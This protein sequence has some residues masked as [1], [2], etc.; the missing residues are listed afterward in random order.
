M[1]NLSIRIGD[2][3]TLRKK[4]TQEE[5][6]AY[7]KS[8]LDENPVHFDMDYASKTVFKK[9]IVHGLFAASLFGGLLGSKLPGKGTIHLGQ[10]LKFIKPIFI[11]EQ[12]TATIEII[13][14]RNDKPIVT[15]NCYILKENN[16]IAIEGKAIVMYKGEFFV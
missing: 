7:A 11:G 3:A 1:N 13:D 12:V 14:I 2:K 16:S 9:P 5:V 8:S 4:F 15:F 10:E 6:I